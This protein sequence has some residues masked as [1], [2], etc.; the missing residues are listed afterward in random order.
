MVVISL[1]CF[2]HLFIYLFIFIAEYYVVIVSIWKGAFLCSGRHWKSYHQQLPFLL[3]HAHNDQRVESCFLTEEAV[4]VCVEHILATEK[5]LCNKCHPGEREGTGQTL[6]L[7][8]PQLPS[9]TEIALFAPIA[10]FLVILYSCLFSIL[11]LFH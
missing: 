3:Y 10:F 9:Y 5:K 7:L 2:L 4:Y 6:G 11:I 8:I 1:K